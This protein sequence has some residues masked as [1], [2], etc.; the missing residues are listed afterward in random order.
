MNEDI[1]S[2][3]ER[4][5][6]LKEQGALTQAEFDNQKAALMGSTPPAFD[7]KQTTLS[8]P[9][10]NK[11]LK[12][13][14]GFFILTMIGGVIDKYE[15]NQNGVKG[16]TALIPAAQASADSVNAENEALRKI[17][18]DAKYSYIFEE[19]DHRAMHVGKEGIYV[20]CLMEYRAKNSFGGYNIE[21]ALVNFNSDMEPIQVVPVE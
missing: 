9:K 15:E 8:K 11:I 14:G 7:R 12:Y 16:A 6:K 10:K 5:A 3:L 18:D 17:D 4:L 2:K 1:L 20:A 21:K 19:I 13:V